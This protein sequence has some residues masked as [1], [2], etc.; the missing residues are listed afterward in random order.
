MQGLPD[1]VEGWDGIGACPPPIRRGRTEGIGK[2]GQDGVL[3]R[4]LA[5]EQSAEDV[6]VHTSTTTRR[7][8]SAT[9]RG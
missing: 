6:S 3:T 1:R 2:R 8:S 9:R 4:V 5:I 7:G